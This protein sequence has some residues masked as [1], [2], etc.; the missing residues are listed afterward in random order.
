MKF[1]IGLQ[2]ESDHWLR[3]E[4]ESWSLRTKDTER[5][6]HLKEVVELSYQILIRKLAGQIIAVDNEASFQLQLAYILKTIGQLYEFSPNDR[7]FIELENQILLKDESIKSKS[8]RARIDIILSLGDENRFATCA[9]ELKFFKRANRREPNNRYDVFADLSNLES[10]KEKYTDLSYLI[11]GTD[12]PHYV[13]QKNYS[14]NTKDFDFRDGKKYVA[15]T[16]LEYRTH[17]PYGDPI[18][19][20]NSYEFKWIRIPKKYPFG[21]AD[22]FFLKIDV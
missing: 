12:H 9:I 11:V 22:L 17:T 1:E 20:R 8:K 4:K 19:L 10:Y 5:C 6:D 15:G 14:E 7:F 13:N 16:P 21:A 3:F 18:V 2:T